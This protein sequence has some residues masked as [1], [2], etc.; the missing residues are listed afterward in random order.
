MAGSRI[1]FSES[2]ASA[3]RALG[4]PVTTGQV[5]TVADFDEPFELVVGWMVIEHFHH[6]V[7]A[8]QKLYDWTKPGGWLAI[9]VPNAG[10]TEFRLFK[11]NWYALHLPAHLSHFTPETI[12]RMLN[13][14]GW[15]VE[16]VLHQRI[17][18]NLILSFNY[19]VNERFPGSYFSKLME[20]IAKKQ[21]FF[22]LA[23]YPL[24]FVLSFFGQTGRM[25]I[26][27]RKPE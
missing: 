21:R 18:S 10:S 13:K 20:W 17:L 9:S 4:Y 6:P 23:L 26:W 2:A 11:N 14:A 24:S 7:K 12:E 22:N 27:A 8:L 15:T 25:T 1:E 5:E 3:A 19:W 16:K